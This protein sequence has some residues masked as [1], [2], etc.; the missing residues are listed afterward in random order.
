MELTDAG[1]YVNV[2]G[3]VY[4]PAAVVTCTMAGPR[5]PAGV[6]AVTVVGEFTVTLVA[7]TP[8]T[9]TAVAVLRYDP[10]TVIVVPPTKHPSFGV[11][12]LIA[13]GHGPQR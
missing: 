12:P 6:V 2:C 8:P 10:V 3:V 1:M 7:G 13:A 4:V 9:V 5:T 11:T